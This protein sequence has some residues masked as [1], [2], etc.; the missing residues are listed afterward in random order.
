MKT[1]IGVYGKVIITGIVVMLMLGLLLGPVNKTI[2]KF[3]REPVATTDTK[4]SEALLDD[5]STRENPTIKIGAVRMKVGRSYNLLDRNL[6]RI[7]SKNADGNDC[8]FEVTKI[9]A[10]DGTEID[11]S[12]AMTFTPQISGWYKVT[13]RAYEYYKTALKETTVTK[14]MAVDN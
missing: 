4:D 6:F 3:F 2:F 11:S 7:E 5:I 12:Q 13:Y 14:N 1:S 9:I 10:S 8:S